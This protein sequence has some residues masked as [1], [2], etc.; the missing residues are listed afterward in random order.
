MV[1]VAIIGGFC[2]CLW[3]ISADSSVTHSCGLGDSS[4]NFPWTLESH[5]SVGAYIPASPTCHGMIMII[6][7]EDSVIFLMFGRC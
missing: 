2:W 7:Q 1:M 5:L 3:P 6:L 4:I